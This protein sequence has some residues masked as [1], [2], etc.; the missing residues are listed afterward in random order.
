MSAANGDKGPT[1]WKIISRKNLMC[2]QNANNPNKRCYFVVTLF[3]QKIEILARSRANHTDPNTSHSLSLSSLYLTFGPFFSLSHLFLPCGQSC[4]F[5]DLVFNTNFHTISK[6][7]C[8]HQ[9]KTPKECEILYEPST[10]WLSKEFKR[11]NKW[12]KTIEQKKP[13]NFL[14]KIS[15]SI[16][17]R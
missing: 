6:L 9:K 14:H 12:Q 4:S 15:M 3:K 13:L 5:F 7:L 1:I 10:L 11:R 16:D 2:T 17:L 8:F